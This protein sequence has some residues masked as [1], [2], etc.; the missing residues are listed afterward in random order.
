MNNPCTARSPTNIRIW[1]QIA[2]KSMQNTNYILNIA[3]P[4]KYNLILIQEPWFGHLGKT[5]G[6]H[7]WCI[8]YPPSIYHNNHDPIQ[9]IILVNTNLSTNM[10]TTLDI[11]CSDILAI[12]LRGDFSHCSIF[13]IYN[14]C[15]N[16]NVTTALHNY[17]TNHRPDTLPLPNNHMLWLGDFNCHHPLWEPN[18]NRHLYNLAEVINPLLDLITE[19]NMIIV[20]PPDI[21][22][23][24]T[25]TSNWT[26]PDNVWHKNSTTTQS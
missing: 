10:Y 23:Y 16:N 8:V 15:I 5:W 24:E 18:N 3:D 4:S 21:P 20:L 6:T 17:L 12:C 25:I 22:T 2:R 9:L 7:N 13:N 1:Q 26:H 11:P 14:D 19:H